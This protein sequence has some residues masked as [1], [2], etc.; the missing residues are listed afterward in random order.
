M[1]LAITC[2]FAVVF[3]ALAV[4]AFGNPNGKAGG[5]LVSGARGRGEVRKG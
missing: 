5:T 4:S 1:E 3:L 2:V